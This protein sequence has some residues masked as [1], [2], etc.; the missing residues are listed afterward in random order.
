[1]LL[2]LFAISGNAPIAAAG[3]IFINE[4]LANPPST[5]LPNEYIEL[6]GVPS[7]TIPANTYFVTLNGDSSANPGDVHSILNLSGLT[8]GSNGY[9]VFVQAGNTYSVPGVANKITSTNSGFTGLPGGIFTADPNNTGLI[10]ATA[11]YLLIQTNT[12][13]TLST[14]IDTNNDAT[15]DGDWSTWTVL[16]S[17]SVADSSTSGDRVYGLINFINSAG[18]ATQTTG[19]SVAVSFSAD[20]VARTAD[21]TGSAA[22][23]WVT[24]DELAGA[25]PNWVLGTATIPATFVSKALNHIGKPNFSLTD[26]SPVITLNHNGLSAVINDPTQPSFSG[27][28]NGVNITVSDVETAPASLIVSAGSPSNPNILTSATLVTVNAAT[29]SYRLDLG[30][31]GNTVGYATVAINVTDLDGNTTLV[32]FQYALSNYDATRPNALW[33]TGAADSSAAFAVDGSYTIIADDEDQVLRMY[34]RSASGLF[35][36]SFDFTSSLGLTDISGGNPRE[37]DIEGAAR[38]GNRIYWMGSHSNSSGGSIRVNRYRL[39]ATD[40]SGSGSGSV[41]TYIGRYDLLRTDLINWDV[42]NT[43]GLGA[44]F[45]GLSASAANGVVPETIGGFNMEAFAVSPDGMTGYV[46]FRAPIIPATNRTKSLVIPI[47]NY[48]ALVSG[49]PSTGPATF[50]APLQWELGGRGV[51][52][53]QCNATAGCLILAGDW[54]SAGNFKLYTWTGNPADSPQLRSADLTGLNP[55]AIIDLPAAFSPTSPIQLV[56]DQGDTI[57]YNDGTIAKD[58]A[59][60]EHKKSRVDTVLLGNPPATPTPTATQ[61][62]LPSASPTSTPTPTATMTPVALP[63]TIGLYLSGTWY[64]RNSNTSGPANITSLFGGDPSD[65]PV[66]GDWNGDQIDTIGVYRNNVGVFFLSDSN[67]VPSVAYSFVFG[68]PGDQPFAGKWTADMIGSG[69]GVYRDTNGIL[70]QKKQLVTGISDYFA[71]FGNPGDQPIAGDWNGNGLDSIGIYRSAN[72]TWYLSNNS[73]PSGITF[74]DVDF[75]YDAGT[76]RP[77]A[78]DWNNDG[79]ATV[80]T[81][82]GT[83]GAFMI[84]K[85]ANVNNPPNFAVF[86]FGP[87]SSVSR[88]VAGKWIGGSSPAPLSVISSGSGQVVNVSEGA[89]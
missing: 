73:S 86:A 55:E 32:N 60:D 9:L 37:V 43:H 23:D 28:G 20:Y 70:Y 22:A 62:S 80:G 5:D 57:Y 38:F 10:N 25:N 77:F 1:L 50:G 56:S 8:F 13:P 89:E 15:P 41:L 24:A 51:R 66:V 78:G 54:G 6:R 17:V 81:H 45:F 18:N 74:G 3:P 75:T 4:I 46:G 85:S 82:S 7:S 63:D 69:A 47:T 52:D 14:D 53:M 72:T 39:F 61:T 84:L 65:L 30:A 42:N 76:H 67:S 71:I 88:P 36:S 83:G 64:L 31:P 12:A 11:S 35:V 59:I 49:N 19:L 48:T 68:N 26:N 34:S 27:V 21:T 2:T 58:L 79:L 40:I 33:L 44:N 16:D 29:G 87:D